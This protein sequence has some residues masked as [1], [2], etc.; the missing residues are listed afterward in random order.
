MKVTITWKYENV[1][2]GNDQELEQ[3]ERKVQVG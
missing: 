3:S 1:K 2:V